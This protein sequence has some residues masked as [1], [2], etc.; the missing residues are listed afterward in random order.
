MRACDKSLRR[1]DPPRTA[2]FGEGAC[3]AA[4]GR[5]LD[6]YLGAECVL[7]G[8][9][10]TPPGQGPW[11]AVRADDLGRVD[12]ALAR[13]APDL[14]LGSS[15]EQRLRPAAAFVPIAPPIRGRWR[16]AA[17]PFAGVQG[18][19]ALVEAVLNACTAE[20]KA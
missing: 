3:I 13:S 8:Y 4:A 5:I 1:H 2:L 15:F 18:V 20:R 7:L 11:E 6:R 12:E 9:R 10:D 17:V 14:V 16:L 19:L